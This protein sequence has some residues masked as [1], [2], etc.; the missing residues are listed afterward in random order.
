VCS[1]SSSN[2][3][4]VS[5]KLNC[6]G[7]HFCSACFERQTRCMGSWSL[8]VDSATVANQTGRRD[9]LGE[10]KCDI[11][12]TLM[13]FFI[14]LSSTRL[15]SL[16]SCLAIRPLKNLQEPSQPEAAHRPP[17]Y[18]CVGNDKHV[19]GICKSDYFSRTFITRFPQQDPLTLSCPMPQISPVPKARTC[20]KGQL[21]I[22]VVCWTCRWSVVV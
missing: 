11:L 21:T 4:I 19:T 3:N 13:A 9:T 22:A 14:K 5:A 15:S 2:L 1:I 10:A 20:R 8:L 17:S 18:N 12:R 7:T 6:F 16:M